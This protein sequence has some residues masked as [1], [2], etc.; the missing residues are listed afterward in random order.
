[1]IDGWRELA[2]VMPLP[3]LIWKIMLDSGYYLFVGALPDGSRRQANMRMLCDK[4]EAYAAEGESSLY[5][6]IKYV[7]TIRAREV[8][9]P[10]ARMVGEKEDAVRIMTMHKSKGL[11][12]PMVIVTGMSRKLT[13]ETSG[14]LSFHKDLGL[15]LRYY[16]EFGRDLGTA[17]RP[18]AMQKLIVERV[19]AEE[20]AEQIRVL[21]VAMTRARDKL[22]LT[23]TVE[24][25]EKFAERA[26][27]ELRTGSSYLN[28]ISP[29]CDHRIVSMGSVLDLLRE[30]DTAASVRNKEKT[31]VSGERPSGEARRALT[32]D[33]KRDLIAQLE[34]IY[35]YGDARSIRSKFSVT[36]INDLFAKA[37]RNRSSGGDDKG[38]DDAGPAA[39]RRAK[40]YVPS[41]AAAEHRLTAAE[42]G[43]IYHALM[44]KIDFSEIPT[45]NRTA[46][47]AK[48]RE[49]LDGFPE[50][51]LFGKEE[52]EAVDASNIAAFFTSGIG[53]R[54][55]DAAKSGRLGKERAFT[56][57][58]RS[59]GEDI[60]V[61]GIIDCFFTEETG[62]ELRTVLVD[63]KSNFFDLRKP[64]EEERR[65]K[66]A[67]AGQIALYRR[68]LER[69]GL[70][71]VREAYLYLLAVKRLIDMSDVEWNGTEL[72][73]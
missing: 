42:R 23:G 49:I 71:P 40:L 66:A 16:R 15:G 65:L 32:E 17:Y 13:Y 14:K 12:F 50:A 10:E 69:A 56:M 9:M 27:T 7:D 63:Y 60:L 1:M 2:R 43:T 53:K 48:I 8:S 28:M 20:L 21:Y 35:P 73:F 57:K 4:A 18:T 54:T 30:T 47:E 45:D 5:G 68:A 3:D 61:Q 25:A 22:Y 39:G 11:E 24:D 46:A 72:G 33:E 52:I 51:G 62:G 58:L 41:F 38:P 67:Y 59:R 6:F 70:P 64:E 37:L 29:H 34:Y 36:E 26:M 44:E 31:A 55:V 19:R